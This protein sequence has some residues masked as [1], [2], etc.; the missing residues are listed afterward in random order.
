[1]DPNSL[2]HLP[3]MAYMQKLEQAARPQTSFA[4]FDVLTPEEPIWAWQLAKRL[5]SIPS[6]IR[7]SYTS[8][9]PSNTF[10]TQFQ[11]GDG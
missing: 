8:Q 3:G 7:N 5:L 2:Q 10:S 4:E 9:T 6:N 1:M 11:Q